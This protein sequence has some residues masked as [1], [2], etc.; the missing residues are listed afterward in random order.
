[1][2]LDRCKDEHIQWLALMCGFGGE[3]K[4]NNFE[5]IGIEGL[6]DGTLYL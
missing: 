5:V 6:V 3:T 1:M 4:Q 2:P